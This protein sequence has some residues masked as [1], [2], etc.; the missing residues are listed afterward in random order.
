MKFAEHDHFGGWN[1]ED[2]NVWATPNDPRGALGEG[3]VTDL[4]AMR[5]HATGVP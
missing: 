2:R 4:V 3:R 5:V 1:A